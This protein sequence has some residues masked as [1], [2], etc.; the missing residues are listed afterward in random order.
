VTPATSRSP[1]RG[2]L[3]GRLGSPL[4]AL[5]RLLLVVSLLAIYREAQSFVGHVFNVLLLFIFASIIA[6]VDRDGIV[7]DPVPREKGT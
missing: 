1:A 6:V 4:R 3:W 7:S 2:S 5:V